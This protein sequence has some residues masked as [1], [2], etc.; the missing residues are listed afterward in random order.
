MQCCSKCQ[1]RERLPRLS[2]GQWLLRWRSLPSGGSCKLFVSC[3]A[4]QAVKGFQI[5]LI[6]APRDLLGLFSESGITRLNA[7]KITLV[8]SWLCPEHW[9]PE[10]RIHFCRIWLW[11]EQ[12]HTCSLDYD[13]KQ[14]FPF[15][16]S[17]PSAHAKLILDGHKICLPS[18]MSFILSL[19]LYIER[20]AE[21]GV[22]KQISRFE[23]YDQERTLVMINTWNW[24]QRD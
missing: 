6:M 16:W 23:N 13:A 15:S 8:T 1:R 22:R 24:K 12:V 10:G 7:I 5:D 17:C 18:G 21:E 3:N 11:D 14:R 4:T 20:N 2:L 19:Q 9:K